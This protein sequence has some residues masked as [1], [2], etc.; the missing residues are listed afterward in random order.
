MKLS[1]GCNF[2]LKVSVAYL[3]LA[4]GEVLDTPE[5]SQIES[6]E[7]DQGQFTKSNDESQKN[8]VKGTFFPRTHCQKKTT[9]CP[10][11]IGL[12]LSEK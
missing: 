12:T 11:L 4:Q 1:N 7:V 9:I 6:I 8:R 5:S 10:C 2:P 3:I